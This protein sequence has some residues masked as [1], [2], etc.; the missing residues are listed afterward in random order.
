M[1]Q[2]KIVDGVTGFPHATHADEAGRSSATLTLPA[3]LGI[4][5]ASALHQQL[6]QAAAHDAPVT[7]QASEIQ[8][9]HTAALQLFCM[10]CSDRRRAGRETHWRE[11]SPA[12]R[13][14]AALLGATT[15]LAL[16]QE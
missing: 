8:R 14:A 11:P 13:S 15:L 1:S 9:I 12:L 3:E 2:T 7:L 10:F 6:L 16:G 5:Q 4:E